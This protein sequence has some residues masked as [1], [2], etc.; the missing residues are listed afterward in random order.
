MTGMFGINGG[1]FLVLL[2]VVV[3][4][5][6]PER[7]PAYA[8]RL[9]IWVRT[10]RGFLRDA[11]KRVDEELTEQGA[12]VDWASLDP[13]RYDP[14][15]IVREALLDDPPMSAAPFSSSVS[16]R[17]PTIAPT[18]PGP[19]GGASSAVGQGGAVVGQ[20]SSVVGQGG[21]AG[22]GSTTAELP[23]AADPPAKAPAS[24][25]LTD[26][27][28]TAAGMTELPHD[29]LTSGGFPGVPGSGS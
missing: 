3:V 28:L 11:K 6:G 7:L 13:R 18:A 20:G 25:A 26:A 1:E 10:M 19:E 12:D 22:P 4:V 21:G 16:L 14:R 24:V 5:V 17:K 8:E 23:P 27:G 29:D 2:V 15:R 9:G